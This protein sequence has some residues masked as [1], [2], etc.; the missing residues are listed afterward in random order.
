MAVSPGIVIVEW[1]TFSSA[2]EPRATLAESGL[3][4][5]PVRP[6]TSRSP[7]QAMKVAL[8]ARRRAFCVRLV[9][10]WLP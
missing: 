2:A 10:I 9:F 8:A 6:E 5:A 3:S 4:A 1:S 7:E